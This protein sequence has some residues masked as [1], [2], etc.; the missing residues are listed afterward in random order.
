MYDKKK[1]SIHYDGKSINDR[2]EHAAALHAA[3]E[4]GTKD[5]PKKRNQKSSGA[6]HCSMYGEHRNLR[7]YRHSEEGAG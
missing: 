7:G 1:Q 2:G 6:E 5:V 3:L 4:E